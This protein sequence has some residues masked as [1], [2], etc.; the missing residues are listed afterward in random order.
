MGGVLDWNTPS[1]RGNR[2]ILLIGELAPDVEEMAEIAG[3]Q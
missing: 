3:S 1:V 2:R